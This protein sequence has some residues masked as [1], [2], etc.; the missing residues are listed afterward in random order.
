MT[1]I[2][3]VDLLGRVFKVMKTVIYFIIIISILG[4]EIFKILIYANHRTCD[5]TIA[6]WTQND[7][8]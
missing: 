6:M 5:V 8:K 7:V 3:F 2:F 4:C 1:E